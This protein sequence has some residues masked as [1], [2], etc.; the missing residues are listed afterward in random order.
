MEEWIEEII[1]AIKE[2]FADLMEEISESIFDK[3]IQWIYQKIFEAIG[4]FFEMMGA[5]GAE[6]FDYQWIKAT[7]A[8]FTLLGWALF[9]CGL[10]VAVF[11]TAM[12]YQNGENAFKNLALNAIRG[13]FA[14]SLIGEIPIKLYQ[15]CISLQGKFT[16][17]LAVAFSST[18]SSGIKD[19]TL[20]VFNACFESIHF[21]VLLLFMMIAFIYCVIKIFFQNMMR[22]GILLTE[23][24]VGSLYM[25]SVPRGYVD[26][27]KSWM[28]QVI[29]IC[30]TSFLQTTLL[31]LGLMTF[32]E[33]MVYGLGIMFA[34]KEVPRICKQF[35]LDTSVN[36]GNIVNQAMT[37]V[38][39]TNMVRHAVT[40]K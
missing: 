15:F 21:S 8:F 24:A 9:I 36:V 27:F 39:I 1:D 4:N 34:A 12:Q 16:D 40:K 13:F 19:L 18:R 17:D 10:V 5:M 35:G 29:A 25:F 20:S 26:G 3:L 30:V 22:G 23:I 38:R 11:D 32:A 31:Y 14:C 7:V 37:S 33:N 28:K 2:G 6:I